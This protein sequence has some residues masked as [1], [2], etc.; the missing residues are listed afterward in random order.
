MRELPPGESHRHQARPPHPLD[1][2]SLNMNLGESTISFVAITS[3][4]AYR[5]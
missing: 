4:S 2:E 5:E 1:R 3:P